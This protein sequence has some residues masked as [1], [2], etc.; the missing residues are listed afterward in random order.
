MLSKKSSCNLTL[1]HLALTV[2]LCF[3]CLFF[4]F[5]ATAEVMLNYSC[6]II[7]SEQFPFF[8]CL[9]FFSTSEEMLSCTA[10][11][12][13][14]NKTKDFCLA[15]YAGLKHDLLLTWNFKEKGREHF[16]LFTECNW[17]T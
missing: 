8:L 3:V 15:L 5:A 1:F 13:P 7:S 10:W 14:I 12:I 2:F 16:L 9:F 4:V 17:K 11:A 6:G